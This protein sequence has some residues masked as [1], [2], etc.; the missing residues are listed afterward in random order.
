VELPLT[1]FVFCCDQSAAAHVSRRTVPHIADLMFF[2]SILRNQRTLFANPPPEAT[3]FFLSLSAS[4]SLRMNLPTF[5]LLARGT[6]VVN[7]PALNHCR[8]AKRSSPKGYPAY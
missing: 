7:G 3:N 4:S 2:M 1:A 8:L 5:F 6:S